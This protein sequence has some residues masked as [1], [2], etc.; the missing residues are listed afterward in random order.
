MTDAVNFGS[1]SS[2]LACYNDF[3]DDTSTSLATTLLT[4]EA[5]PATREPRFKSCPLQVTR[6]TAKHKAFL[7]TITL[8]VI[9]TGKR[10][11]EKYF[12]KVYANPSVIR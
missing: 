5:S 1:W 9:L 3:E 7:T 2:H 12:E 4:S 8:H 6:H 10:I 11:F